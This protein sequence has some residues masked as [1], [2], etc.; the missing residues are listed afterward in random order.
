MTMT[1]RTKRQAYMIKFYYETNVRM[2]DRIEETV[3]DDLSQHPVQGLGG[4]L[5][6]VCRGL[7]QLVI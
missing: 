4:D 1:N 5:T 3:L 2:T 6:G 7:A